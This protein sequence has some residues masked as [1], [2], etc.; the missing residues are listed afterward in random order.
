MQQ[1]EI[2]QLRDQLNHLEER[3]RA[4]TAS[5]TLNNQVPPGNRANNYWDNFRS[6]SRQNLLSAN[7][8]TNADGHLS[9]GPPHNPHPLVER[10]H[11]TLHQTVPPA[12]P[13]RNTNAPSA[14]PLDDQQVRRRNLAYERSL[15]FSSA[16]DVL[17]LNSEEPP[18]PS[19]SRNDE[20]TPASDVNLNRHEPNPFRNFNITNPIPEIIQSHSNNLNTSANLKKKSSSKL[21]AKN[22]SNRR[23][24]ALDYSQTSNVNIA[25][26]SETPNPNL[27][28][29]S[30]EIQEKATSK[31]F[32]LLREN[33][34]SEV[35]TLIGVN[36]SHP[37][38]L[39]QLFRELQLVSSD[40]LRQ[41]I[42]QSI[43]N[44][45]SQYSS[46]IENQN[47]D[48]IQDESR[49]EAVSTTNEPSN[50][51]DCN[52]IQNACSS[53]MQIDNKIIR[54]LLLK[55]E[56]V[57]TAE[58]LEALSAL[59]L[60]SEQNRSPQMKKRLQEMLA[61]YEGMRVCDV[62]SDIIEN[63][64]T[65]ASNE[66]DE[67]NQLTSEV[68]ESSILQDVAGSLNLFSS[69]DPQLHQM[70]CPYD[71][72]PGHVHMEIENDDN[73]PRSSQE[74]KVDLINC[75]E[76]HNGDLAEA[77]QTCRSEGE[78]AGAEHP[79]ASPPDAL[80]DV[81]DT[82]EVTPT[83]AEAEWLGLDRVPTRLHMEESSEK[84][85]D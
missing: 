6:Y 77:D 35:T 54:F 32:D 3:W 47:E 49:T 29:T 50:Y 36:E 79:N 80:P 43:R 78:G 7:S 57:C 37:D 42:L 22:S 23:N 19:H 9:A 81:V 30:R 34:Y 24:Y 27:A 51:H 20:T 60:S 16:P 63:L 45:L 76:M 53:T 71:M 13:K 67:S 70:N 72:W 58:F 66:G 46:V 15:S 18:I 64:P 84:Q 10:S 12:P 61:K 2:H 14:P 62:T 69:S 40:P 55:S 26:T 68:S 44:V 33:V 41:R 56:D 11:N 74:G 39:I 52:S 25:S 85:K 48:E 83:E 82:E 1:R 75:T 5:H 73:S 31:L 28:S 4:E 8:K 65:F 38:F 59:I 21:P 17:N